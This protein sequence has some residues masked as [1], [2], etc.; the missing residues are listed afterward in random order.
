MAGDH[1]PELAHQSLLHGKPQAQDH[2]LELPHSLLLTAVEEKG[3]DLPPARGPG[4]EVLHDLLPGLPFPP[5]PARRLHPAFLEGE[6]GLDVE[7]GP[8]KG[9]G[10]ADAPAPFQELQGGHGETHEVVGPDALQ[11]L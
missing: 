1:G 10:P 6:D 2:G 11:L 5:G 7:E 9:L 4:P 3:P 8:Q